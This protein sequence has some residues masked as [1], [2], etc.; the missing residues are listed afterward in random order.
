VTKTVIKTI[1]S[2]LLLPIPVNPLSIA[3]G[4]ADIASASERARRYGWM[5]F[6]LDLRD[7]SK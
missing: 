3:V 5:Y 4:I 2:K 1:A 7:P 6:L